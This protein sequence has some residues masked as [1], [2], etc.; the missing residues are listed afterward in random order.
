VN[1]KGRIVGDVGVGLGFHAFTWKGGQAWT[2]PEGTS[3]SRSA[4]DVNSCGAIV[5]SA[6][7]ADGDHAVL[8]VRRRC[9]A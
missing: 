2:L 5:G 3:S 6:T 9:E 4:R 1:N 7:F 8:W